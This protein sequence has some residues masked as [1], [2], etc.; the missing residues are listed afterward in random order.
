[1][2]VKYG[3]QDIEF[4]IDYSVKAKNSYITVERDS[5]VVV[6]VPESLN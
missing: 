1:M 6:K 5:G 4:T 2:I 3:T